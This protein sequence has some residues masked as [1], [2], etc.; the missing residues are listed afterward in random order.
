MVPALEFYFVYK[1]VDLYP[2]LIEH[3]VETAVVASATTS[4]LQTV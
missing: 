1:L 3:L 2:E 4:A